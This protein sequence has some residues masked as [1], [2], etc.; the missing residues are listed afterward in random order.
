MLENEQN[1][2]E[3]MWIN[4]AKADQPAAFSHIVNSYQQSIYN[5]CYR[6]LQDTTEAEDATQETFLRAYTKLDVYNEN[7]KFST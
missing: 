6:M 5:L 2:N 1:H 4:Q 7:Y 3:S